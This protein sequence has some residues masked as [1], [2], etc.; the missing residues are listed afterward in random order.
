MEKQIPMFPDYRVSDFGVTALGPEDPDDGD[1]GPQMRGMA[2][3]AK[4]HIEKTRI[5]YKVPSQSGNGST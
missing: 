5:G 2:I 1:Q 3:A 4:V